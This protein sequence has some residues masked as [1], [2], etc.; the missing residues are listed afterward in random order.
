MWPQTLYYLKIIWHC[1]EIVFLV[2]GGVWATIELPGAF[3]HK[4]QKLQDWRA[5]RSVTLAPVRLIKL[6][7]AEQELKAPPD[8]SKTHVRFYVLILACIMLG[9]LGMLSFMFGYLL[10]HASPVVNGPW[11]TG[12]SSAVVISVKKNIGSAAER[13]MLVGA[14]L[15]LI[16]YMA[17]GAGIFYLRRFLPTT[18]RL[19][20][21]RLERRIEAM[22]PKVNEY[23]KRLEKQKPD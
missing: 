18:R 15:F 8:I 17:G 4:Y 21:A 12:P 20:L 1:I 14:I 23:K 22:R 11:W 9:C 3:A 10:S 5:E 7:L 6:L 2:V 16:C 13:Q 19:E